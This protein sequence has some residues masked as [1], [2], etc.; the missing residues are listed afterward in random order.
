[1]DL[2]LIYIAEM[3]ARHEEKENKKYDD[4][5]YF[6]IYAETA[7]R[8]NTNRMNAKYYDSYESRFNY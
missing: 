4:V 8:R 5:D 3:Q 2:D 7:Y 1:M 6:E